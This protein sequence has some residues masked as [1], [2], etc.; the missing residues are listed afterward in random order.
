MLATERGTAVI[1]IDHVVMPTNDLG[2]SLLWFQRTLDARA[3]RIIGVNRRGLDR[4]VPMLVFF[5]LANHSGFGVALQSDPLPPP[6]RPLEGPVCGF[7]IDERGLAGVIDVLRRRG[8]PFDGPVEY[9]APSPIAASIFVQD[10]YQY[11]YE[12]SVRRDPMR[13]PAPGQGDMG[14]RRISHVRL[15]VTDLQRAGE[16]YTAVLGLEPAAPVH[17]ERQLTLAVADSGQLFVLR[18]V[19]EMTGRSLFTRGVHVDVKVPVG[20]YAA[21]SAR[22]DNPERY[23]GPISDR[24]PWHEPTQPT[25][26]FYDPFFNRLQLSEYKREG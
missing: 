18:E 24:T 12:L 25:V 7:E 19:P 13:D 10:P 17:G 26:Y 15:D 22:I 1:R 11:V 6:V 21:A 4:E 8:V 23:Q 9:P 3:P 14:L 2:Q 20:A 16:W 5:T